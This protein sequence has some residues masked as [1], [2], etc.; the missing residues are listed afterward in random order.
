MAAGWAARRGAAARGDRRGRRGARLRRFLPDV[1]PPR[2]GE[3]SRAPSRA[4]PSV[5]AH[6]RRFGDPDLVAIG[7]AAPGPAALYS[8][9]R[10]RGARPLRRGDGRCRR[11]RA[12]RRSSPGTST[13]SM[14]E[15]CQEISDFGRAAEWTAALTRWCSAQPGLVAFTGQCAVHRGQIMR[16]HGA[17]AR[18]P[19]TSSRAPSR[20]TWPRPTRQPPGWPS[21]R[22]GDVLRMLG[23]LERA[24]ASY[25]RAADHG[26]RARSPAWPCS[27]SRA[28]RTEAA[29]AAV[30]PAAGRDDRTPWRGPGCCPRRSR[31]CSPAATRTT[32][33]DGGARA[34]GDRR[35]TSAAP[36]CSRDG[37]V[38]LG[39]G[40]A[41]RRGPGRRAALPAQGVGSCGRA[42]DAP[43]EAARARVQVGRALPA[44][45][46]DESAT[47]ELAAAR[48]APRRARR[49]PAARRGRPTA[50]AGR[51]CPTG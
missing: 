47:G 20:A 6:G 37:G 3:D 27:G 48:R 41:G 35:A 39:R 21:P 23:E 14:I 43:Y 2:R 38:R 17:F 25:E 42:L 16:L 51:R 30:A 11:G 29:L 44:L 49:R 8:G 36:R 7:L 13:A 15:G 1:R 18:R 22:R 19:S 45:G 50:G 28:G 33:R 40:R 26:L 10:A 31:C 32:A 4:P 34:G 12:S 46:D 24:E 9:R 5:T